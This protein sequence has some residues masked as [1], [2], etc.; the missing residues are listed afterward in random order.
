MRLVDHRAPGS[1]PHPGQA[2]REMLE[3]RGWSQVK[4]AALIGMPTKHLNRFGTG[5]VGYSD[6]SRP[7]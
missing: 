2:L 1:V 4:F 5:H 3:Q 7:N 6:S